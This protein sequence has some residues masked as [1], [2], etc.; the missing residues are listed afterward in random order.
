[1]IHPRHESIDVT[2]KRIGVRLPTKARIVALMDPVT[3]EF[4]GDAD[5]IA[6]KRSGEQNHA[7]DRPIVIHFPNELAYI[8]AEHVPRGRRGPVNA[9]FDD[10]TGEFPA[11]AEVFERRK[12][13][14]DS[15]SLRIDLSK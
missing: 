2:G 12:R 13:T 14:A 9:S 4:V 8:A 7:V 3:T 5:D 11:T 6:Q 10:S 15:V 1:M